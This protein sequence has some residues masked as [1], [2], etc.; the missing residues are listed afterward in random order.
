MHNCTSKRS[1]LQDRTSYVEKNQTSVWKEEFY[2]KLD[3]V[4]KRKG[5]ISFGSF[6]VS[7][8]V[9]VMAPH[10]HIA[11]SRLGLFG[12][13]TLACFQL[14]AAFQNCDRK[15]NNFSSIPEARYSSNPSPVSGGML[16]LYRMVHTFLDMVQPNPFPTDI[17]KLL[18]EN[19]EQIQH[20]YIKVVEYEVGFI[21]CAAIGIL[22]FILM[23]L[24]GVCFCCCRCCGNCG[25]K[26]YQKQT[27]SM[28][29]K[30]RT[31][32]A[33]LLLVTTVIFAGNVCM[34]ISNEQ[35]T[36][37]IEDSDKLLS[38]TFANLK[39][40]INTI[41]KQ[42][43]A[44]TNASSVPVNNVIAN[45]DNIG[46]GLGETVREK[47]AETAYPALTSISQLAQDINEMNDRLVFI[48]S[49]AAR[50]LHQQGVLQRNLT[51]IRQDISGTLNKCGSLCANSQD[52][53]NNLKLVANFSTVPDMDQEMEAMKI[54]MEANLQSIVQEGYKAFNDTPA[55]VANQSA[56]TV[57]EMKTSIKSIENQI[58][59]ATQEFPTSSTLISVNS[60]LD[61]V[62]S[63]I[64][65]YLPQV[66]QG[67][68]YRW[69]VG[70]VLSCLIL[71]V[72]V[73]NYL[74]LLLGAACLKPNEISTERSLLSNCGGNL[75]MA[76]V[77]FSFI[78]S[79][80][81]M[82]LVFIVFL[83]GGNVYSLV[84][85]PWYNGDFFQIIET[86]GLIADFN[87]GQFLGL[88]NTSLNINGVYNDCQNN[89]PVW[90][91]LDLGQNFNLNE[92]FNLSK[93]TEEITNKFDKLNI[94]LSEI[95][96]LN[97]KG[98]KILKDLL[99]TGVDDLNFTNILE[100]LGMPLIQTEL[101]IAEEKLRNLSN[102]VSDPFKTE[103]D[104]EAASL[105]EL[106]VWIHSNM[107]PNIGG[108]NQPDIPLLIIN[109]SP[110]LKG[111]FVWTLGQ[112]RIGLPTI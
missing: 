13:V 48:N 45:L 39:T 67:N 68:R 70:I 8:S 59:N 85:K 83:V 12:F 109:Q 54:I 57:S 19:T 81:L 2:R 44:I 104:K 29:C 77:G 99:N 5:R 111:T 75:F 34:F 23:P 82:L 63:S 103:L 35:M 30:R 37:T 38:N 74:G 79:W 106:N 102:T 107:L 66:Q 88:E 42:I 24:V 52:L 49:T 92:L 61:K 95:T 110:L 71:L 91:A 84:C 76:G 101:H 64:N 50:L 20:N 36:D 11:H 7:F 94:S 69:T 46:S 65:E 58:Q 15:Q 1:S 21:V 72:V 80:L 86:S 56:I 33:S 43:T 26:M 97:D 25:G 27:E 62:N 10:W 89:T 105:K 22:F 47:L 18:V 6:P 98:K 28:N 16:V 60:Q 112:N 17:I 3:F 53:V 73:C 51:V 4:K 55:L 96:L 93:D 41:P 14:S 78:F 90:K 87:L 100:Q 9:T 31:L 108:E 40:Y 32:A